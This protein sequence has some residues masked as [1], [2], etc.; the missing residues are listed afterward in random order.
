[1]A[2]IPIP[3]GALDQKLVDF[4]LL[5]GLLN[6]PDGAEFNLDWFQNPL[7]YLEKIPSDAKDILKLLRDIL[8]KPAD[9]TPQDKEWYALNWNGAPTGIYI[10]L[11]L[12]SDQTPP[13][14][15]GVGLWWPFTGEDSAIQIT[16]WVY[17]PLFNLPVATP[18]I[19]TGSANYPVT[20]ALSINDTNGTF[21]ADSGGNPVTFTGLE[22]VG[23]IYFSDTA[24]NFTLQFVNMK[25]A[26]QQSTA[27]T[28]A[29]L[30]NT[31]LA[32]WVNA[33]LGSQTVAGWLSTP[34]PS[35]SKKIGEVLTDLDILVLNGQ[36]SLGALT[37]FTTM[38]PAAIAEELVSEALSILASNNN[39]VFPLGTGGIYIVGE[40]SAGGGTDYGV[41][42][43]VE[44]IKITG[45]AEAA[46]SSGNA[47]PGASSG[48]TAASS[49]EFVLQIGK[50]LT[51]ESDSNN[52]AGRADPKGEM[53]GP[54]VTIL[55]VNIV[56]KT[57]FS[58]KPKVE[59][60]SLGFDF[61]GSND[62][63]LFDIQGT[64][65]GGVELRFSL[66]LD[67]SDL[68]KILWGGAV[69][70]D[71]LGLPLG[72]G[73]TGSSGNPVAQNLLSS[74]SESSSGA[75]ADTQPVNPAFSASV[76]WLSDPDNPTEVNFQLYAPDDTPTDT[77]WIPV[78]Q[79]F[80]PLQCQRLGVEWPQPNPDLRVSFLFDGDVALGGLEID[81]KGLSIGIPLKSPGDLG[82]YE[83]GLDGLDITFS[84]GPV[85]VSGGLFKAHV[86]VDGQDIIEYNGEALIKAA[87]WSISALGSWASLNG[88]PSLFI[89]AFLNAPIGGPAFFFVTGLSAGFGY[90]RSLK[91]P[92]QDQ[93]QNFPFVAGLSDPSKIGGA[94][95]GPQAALQAIQ[96]WVQPAQGVNWIAAGVQFTSFE[97]IN[98][99]ALV[100][101]EFGDH[102]EIAV[103]GLSRIKLPQAGPVTYAYVELGLEVIIDPSDGLFSATAVIT[104][105]SYV[106]DPACHL[107]GG[108]AFFVWFSPSQHAGDFVLTI[109]GYH[110][111]FN[112][113][114]WYPDEPR[115]GFN[116]QLSDQIS[117]K[118]GAYFALTPSC[119]MG[120]GSLDL[121]FHSG[122]LSA[123]F[124]AYA[125]FLIQ[126]KP[127]YYTAD[128]G[129]SI[130][131]SYR[132]HLL[133][134]TTTIKVELG[135]DLNMWGPPTGGEVHVHLW[136]VSFTVSFGPSYGQGNDYLE[137]SDFQTLLPQDKPKSQ[138][139][140]PMM[141]SMAM[142][143]EDDNPPFQN[144]IKLVINAGQYPQ[145]VS[146]GRWLVRADEFT[147]TVE[148]AWPLTELD[149][150]GPSS[151]TQL[152]PP[153]LVPPDAN[154]PSCARSSDG[155]YV[156]VRPMGINCVTS[157]LSLTVTFEDGD[158]Q[159]VNNDWDWALNTRSV[160]EATWGQPISK[161]ATPPPASNTLPGRLTG[162]QN[163]TPKVQQPSG[164]A[165]IPRA[166]L[167]YDPINPDANQENYLPIPQAAQSGQPQTSSTS[168]QTIASTIMQDSAADSPVSNRAAI[169]SALAGFGYD[170]G[171]N[172][173]LSELVSY[174]N[175][176][177]V[178]PPM[179]ES[180][181]GR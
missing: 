109:G 51:G 104:P 86:N 160:P 33:V 144:V 135:A 9:G 89:F 13:Q 161:D 114:E 97:L 140:A 106:I 111:Q 139:P 171:A 24:P 73:V 65:L 82:S 98:S 93:V 14:T 150:V 156:G 55:L 165:P 49:P 35:T 166:N 132:V 21:P 153:T 66:S 121:E 167:S 143:A 178:A 158:N 71:H 112:K 179:L 3:S 29:D 28:L 100:V 56:N 154:A 181:V 96:D 47:S 59:L 37:K 119:V 117:I 4:G 168:L 115:L 64:R 27:Q 122:N 11:P 152:E 62:K 61:T 87:S 76:A 34:I 103:L 32:G 126:W 102:F 101:V 74:G 110:P 50:W 78:Q 23:N 149:L 72:A 36:Y 44:D 118:G 134:V 6:Q 147:F 99:N 53:A 177:F 19:V 107:T 127:F 75:G 5:L 123:W 45:S 124:T 60:M 180:P 22:F 10:V 142:A 58:F 162:L 90:N 31:T 170:A 15:V 130:G 95:A 129:I 1:M 155:Y 7:S 18:V 174:I 48:S 159:D 173:D 16:G 85:D 91:L 63:P 145:P 26:S 8:G 54:G 120:G 12:S 113:P 30:Q 163:I 41:R 68:S 83:L 169:F 81:L 42:L 88:H 38:T 176:S 77:V 2:T 164:P 131:V 69:R 116:W 146:D 125:D 84:Q 148:S 133:F 94:D 46:G 175:L 128:I 136:I 138:Q 52:W 39:P 80:G 141:K 151:T 17:F 92:T 25:P 43:T 108:F 137:F 172:G 40:D 105:N 79:A 157:V 70:L 20:I 57:Q 67:F